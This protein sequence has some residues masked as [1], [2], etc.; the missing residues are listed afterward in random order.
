MLIAYPES[1]TRRSVYAVFLFL[2]VG[3]PAVL[4]VLAIKGGG[5]SWIAISSLFGGTLG[6]ILLCIWCAVYVQKEPRRVRIA[7]IWITV[8]LLIILTMAF[9]KV[10]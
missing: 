9:A 5:P 4:I 3:G 1:N 8:L 6:T 10:P 2:A 7:L